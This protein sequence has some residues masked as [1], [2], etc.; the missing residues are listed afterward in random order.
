[1]LAPLSGGAVWRV[2]AALKALKDRIRKSGFPVVEDYQM[3][4]A[5]ADRVRED[6]WKLI[7]EAYPASEVPDALT[8]ERRRHEAYGAMRLRMYLGGQGYFQALDE[9]LAAAEFQPVLVTGASG[10]G[11]SA[12]LANWVARWNQIGRAHV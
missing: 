1:M 5:L 10:G 9:A 8:L 12:L 2:P 11:K 4:E 7:D 6:L 3:P